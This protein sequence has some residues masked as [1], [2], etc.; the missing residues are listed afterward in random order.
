VINASEEAPE[1]AQQGGLDSQHAAPVNA[2]QLNNMIDQL[3]VQN[4]IQ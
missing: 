4:P 3:Q 2:N 1:Q